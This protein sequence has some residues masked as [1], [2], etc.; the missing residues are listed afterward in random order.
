[1]T[2]IP[3]PRKSCRVTE[4]VKIFTH[5]I[6]VMVL[7]CLGAGSAAAQT[8]QPAS[9][10]AAKSPSIH[11]RCIHA[12]GLLDD[13]SLAKREKI[14]VDTRLRDIDRELHALPFE[15]YQQLDE[16]TLPVSL[17]KKQD[18]KLVTGQMLKLRLIAETPTGLVLWLRWQDRGG[19]LLLDTKIN[20][21]YGNNVIAGAESVNKSG[22]IL[23]LEASP[24]Q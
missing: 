9:H 18:M 14:M 6:G 8:S 16:A 2:A 1:M 11:I 10:N 4:P 21:E 15:V 22:A 17:K 20:L 19:T 24:R 7:L 23:V 13:E 3:N 12:L 5:A